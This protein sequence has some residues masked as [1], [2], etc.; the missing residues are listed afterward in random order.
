[1]NEPSE[2]HDRA[3]GSAPLPAPAGAPASAAPEPWSHPWLE[4]L[5]LRYHRAI[6]QK[7]RKRPQ[8]VQSALANIDRWLT[9][10]DY[11]PGPRRALLEWRGFLTSAS[12]EEVVSRLI[13]PSEQGHQRRQNSPFAGLLTDAERR[14]IREHYEQ[15]T[16]R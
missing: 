16:T 1:M 4:Q 7:I 10:N 5:G 2:M 3:A 9:R 14:A 15:A 12:V 13:D 8:L 6:A 11:P